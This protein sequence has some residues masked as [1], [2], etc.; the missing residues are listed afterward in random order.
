[1]TFG[2]NG[3]FLEENVERF[4]RLIVRDA[5]GELRDSHVGNSFQQ[6]I[7]TSAL[8]SSTIDDWAGGVG[9]NPFNYTLIPIDLTEWY[10]IVATYDPVGINED[11]S[12]NY[13]AAYLPGGCGDCHG[14]VVGWA[15]DNCNCDPNFWRGNIEQAGYIDYSGLGAKCK[16]EI[17]SRTDLLRARGFKE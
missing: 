13:T 4:V 15:G 7:D 12:H 14:D 1:M 17:I 9:V 11:T 2:G 6:R 3:F 16:V 5:G 10:F 8:D